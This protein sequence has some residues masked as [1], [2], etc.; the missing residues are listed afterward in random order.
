M[1]KKSF[2]KD[3]VIVGLA[4][5]STMFGAG[6]L[7]FPPQIGLFSGQEWFLGAMGLLLG[8]I[9]LPVMALWAVN[10]VGEGSEDLMGHV[11][12]WCY[13][14]FYLVSCTLIAMGSTLPKS[15]ATTYEIGIQPLFPQVPNWAVIIVF[16]VL[17]YFFACDRES[18]IDK[19]GKYMTPILLVLL[20]IVLIKGVVTPVGEPV[21]TGIGNPFGDGVQFHALHELLLGDLRR[22]GYDGKESRRGGF[23]AGIVCIIALF[24]V[25]GTL[26]Y[27]GATA[28][29]IYAQDTA[30]TALLSGVIRQIM[31]TAGL[32]CMGGAVAMACLTTAVGIGTTVV[33][34][35]YE[36]L[37]KRVPY[38]LLMLIACIIGVFMGITGVQNIVNYVTPI[39]LVIYPVCIVMTILGLL[40][41]FLP[42]DGFYKG[43]VLMAG[44][45]SLG[46]AVLSVAP[47]IGWLKDLMSMFPLSDLGFAWLAPAVIGAVVGALLCRGKEKY[48]AM[49]DPIAEEIA[50]NE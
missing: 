42:N 19:L 17:V 20:A 44:I 6:N 8:G 9:V 50:K 7:I 16:F 13:N 47:D 18:V 49:G 32:A 43:G 11:S 33:S 48:Q 35:I 28:S 46:D 22:R 34:F 37:K 27:I 26:T 4:L 23:M 15:A 10:N 21:D 39:F 2:W 45:V 30:Q 36:F 5:F 40:D 14:A 38:K 31:G 25:Y 3:T 24:A 12:P 29:G 1:K 41:R